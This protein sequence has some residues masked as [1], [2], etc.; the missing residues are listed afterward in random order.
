[1]KYKGVGEVLIVMLGADESPFVFHAL[2]KAQIR[3]DFFFLPLCL[4]IYANHTII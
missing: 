4:L 3:G 1:M 2:Y